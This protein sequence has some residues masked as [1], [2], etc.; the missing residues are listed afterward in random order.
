MKEKQKGGKIHH[1]PL[2]PPQAVLSGKEARKAEILRIRITQKYL[3]FNCGTFFQPVF[4]T[5]AEEP[6]LHPRFNE[7]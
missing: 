1:C 7:R 4:Q 3:C 6:N 2:L 5:A